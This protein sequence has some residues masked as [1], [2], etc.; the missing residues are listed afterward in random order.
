MVVACQKAQSLLLGKHKMSM[1][2]RQQK[3]FFDGGPHRR[4]LP[5]CPPV[6]KEAGTDGAA[7]RCGNM[8]MAA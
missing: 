4:F 5:M 6:D 1:A 7:N 8:T 3:A 2:C